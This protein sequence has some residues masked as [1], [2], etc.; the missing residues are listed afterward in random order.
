MAASTVR[1]DCSPRMV[2]SKDHN[3]PIEESDGRIEWSNG[4]IIE[5]KHWIVERP[6]VQ[7]RMPEDR[8]LRLAEAFFS[9]YP[10]I[11]LY[12]PHCESDC[13]H[14]P[15]R[16]ST[17]PH[18]RGFALFSLFYE[19]VYQ[20]TFFKYFPTILNKKLI[21][22]FLKYDDRSMCRGCGFH[23]VEVCTGKRRL[24]LF[25]RMRGI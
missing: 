2:A 20:A 24:V 6:C 17:C 14:R 19:D 15:P 7:I 1:L 10:T 8:G 11:F 12:H 21:K 13:D 9:I 25:E 23:S 22:I 5:F 18:S 16:R 3:D 4:S